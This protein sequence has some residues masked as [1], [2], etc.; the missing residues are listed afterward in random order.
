MN[1]C[2]KIQGDSRKGKKGKFNLAS[3]IEISE[4][5]DVVYN[6][7]WKPKPDKKVLL[8]NGAQPPAVTL[9]RAVATTR[10]RQIC[11]VTLSFTTGNSRSSDE[12]HYQKDTRPWH[13]IGMEYKGIGMI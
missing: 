10:S 11:S 8:T 2:A 9:E 3:A 1:R 6:F 5:V 7:E 4:T 13:D 12:T